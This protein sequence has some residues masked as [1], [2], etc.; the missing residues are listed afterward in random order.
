[1]HERQI[2]DCFGNKITSIDQNKVYTYLRNQPL[3]V[4]LFD[5]TNFPSPPKKQ[6][7]VMYRAITRLYLM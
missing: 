5:Q 3:I 4:N 7:T 6:I 1:M 2:Y